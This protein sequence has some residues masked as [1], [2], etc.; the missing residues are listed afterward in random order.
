VHR[1]SPGLLVDRSAPRST[2]RM[3]N[4][5]TSEAWFPASQVSTSSVFISCTR[6]RPP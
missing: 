2:E 4:R 5:C 6:F 1:V 3:E